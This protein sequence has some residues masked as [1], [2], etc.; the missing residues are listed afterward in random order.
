MKY[1]LPRTDIIRR[2]IS[3]HGYP[4]YSY[5]DTLASL[6][7]TVL[8][9]N[10]N[11]PTM[12]QAVYSGQVFEHAP[13]GTIICEVM[14][15]DLDEGSNAVFSFFIESDFKIFSIDQP[16]SVSA[17]RAIAFIRVNDSTLLDFE[18]LPAEV[19][20]TVFAVE[21]MTLERLQSDKSIVIVAI[22][23]INDNSPVFINDPYTTSVD[24]DIEEETLLIK[25]EAYDLDSG[26][27]AEIE[28]SLWFATDNGL[29]IFT[30]DQITG[31]LFASY[32]LD[33]LDANV[34]DSYVVTVMAMDK[35]YI[36]R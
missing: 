34:I 31:E 12:S 5:R 26:Q 15:E 28:Y 9:V 21:T 4:I 30:I 16:T 1:Y 13:Y 18:V 29:D 23:D 22:T 3:S 7:V 14:A 20:V 17:N 27:N 24:D 32:N 10:D 25:I 19:N 36:P 6:V 35:G 33:Q 2:Q 8:D 11:A